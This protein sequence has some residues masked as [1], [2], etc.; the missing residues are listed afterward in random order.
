MQVTITISDEEY[1]QMLQ[2]RLAAMH[3]F[4]DGTGTYEEYLSTR[5]IVR[6]A[7]KVRKAEGAV[8]ENYKQQSAPQHAAMTKKGTD[9]APAE[10]EVRPDEVQA[11]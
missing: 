10:I 4:E 11:A 5:A 9:K 1:S 3:A 7:R 2:D 6:R 8:V